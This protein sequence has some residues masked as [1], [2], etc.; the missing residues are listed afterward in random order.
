LDGEALAAWEESPHLEV[1]QLMDRTRDLERLKLLEVER[2]VHGTVL[3][4]LKVA[5]MAS[6]VDLQVVTHTTPTLPSV[7][8]IQEL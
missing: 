3:Q 1:F 4:H 5:R 6:Q 2:E 8:P 7:K